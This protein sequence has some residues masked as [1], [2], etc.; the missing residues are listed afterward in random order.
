MPELDHKS[1]RNAQLHADPAKSA[2]HNFA[3]VEAGA[4]SSGESESEF[5][6]ALPLWLAIELSITLLYSCIKF[7]RF[8]LVRLGVKVEVEVD[9]N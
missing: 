6:G 4:A 8:Q 1:S 3:N 2:D 9:Q 5:E 7:I